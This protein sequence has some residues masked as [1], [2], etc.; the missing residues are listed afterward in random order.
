MTRPRFGARPVG[1]TTMLESARS[2]PVSARVCDSTR[3]A[4][5]PGGAVMGVARITSPG[6]PSGNGTGGR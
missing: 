3:H 1:A 4:R 6:S 2:S 5:A